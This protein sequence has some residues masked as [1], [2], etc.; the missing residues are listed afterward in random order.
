[1]A[2]E[3]EEDV[4]TVC[5]D[6]VKGEEDIKTHS[7]QDRHVLG[8]NF[9][10]KRLG[11]LK[12]GMSSWWVEVCG[13]DWRVVEARRGGVTGD[14]TG[15]GTRRRGVAEYKRRGGRQRRGRWREVRRAGWENCDFWWN[16]KWNDCRRCRPRERRW[17][18]FRSVEVEL[19]VLVGWTWISF[20]VVRPDTVV[21]GDTALGSDVVVELEPACVRFSARAEK[22]RFHV[23]NIIT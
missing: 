6:S 17:V 3:D 7:N 11:G 21:G 10:K 5:C 4:R 9:L 8:L 16:G 22:R 15:V 18:L 2:K 23:R 20:H 19:D 1:V 14:G 12:K 13:G